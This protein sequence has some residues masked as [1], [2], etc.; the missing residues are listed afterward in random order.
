MSPSP[1]RY[2][3]DEDL[4][5]NSRPRT[6]ELNSPALIQCLKKELSTVKES[7]NEKFTR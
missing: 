2:N 4:S 1:V 6:K 7:Q 3:E 5:D